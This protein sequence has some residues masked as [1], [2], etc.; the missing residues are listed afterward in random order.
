MQLSG[1][2]LL[3][4]N[5]SVYQDL[6]SPK[7][8][9]AKTS[10][11]F[12]K[13]GPTLLKIDNAYEQYYK[14]GHRLAKESLHRLL[15]D[16]L[17][18]HGGFWDKCKRNVASN[19]L[20][21]FV[22]ELTK[23]N[24]L[25]PLTKEQR[26]KNLIENVEV[27]H[28]RYGILYLL[29]NIEIRADCMPILLEGASAGLAI[30][31][32]S[33]TAN[34]NDV[35]SKPVDNTRAVFSVRGKNFTQADI[36]KR[37]GQIAPHLPKVKGAA[38]GVASAASKIPAA[39]SEIPG[40]LKSAGSY[41]SESL[42]KFEYP[43][44]LA[45]LELSA[46]RIDS[47]FNPITYVAVRS[48]DAANVFVEAAAETFENI[49]KFVGRAIR[50][51]AQ[52]LWKKL[53]PPDADP[54]ASAKNRADYARIVK[55]ATKI[56]LNQVL[57]KSVP[58]I[59]DAIDLGSGLARTVDQAAMRIAS[60][61]DRRHFKLRAGHPEELVNSIHGAMEAGMLKGL[62]STIKGAVGV[63]SQFLFAGVGSVVS[64]L[65]TGI[66][67]L[68]KLVCRV[69]E[70]NR[71]SKFLAEAR[72][73]FILEKSFFNAHEDVERRYLNSNPASM[74]TNADKFNEFFKQ[75][76]KASPILPMIVLNSGICTNMMTMLRIFNDVD[77]QVVGSFDQK[78][79]VVFD[80]GIFRYE[81]FNRRLKIYSAEYLRACGFRFKPAVGG[82]QSV[83]QFLEFALKHG[84]KP[85]IT[86][87]EKAAHVTKQFVMA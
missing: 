22:F 11:F 71:V 51:L 37:S 7:E 38:L 43:A 50:D 85:P 19:G 9:V 55:S 17:I 73:K 47:S 10:L 15:H 6:V 72:E 25:M 4:M 74:V 68:V 87:L 46:G 26:A 1:N 41:V 21:Q 52:V 36:I 82:D 42:E 32:T 80:E 67:W 3:N 62:F 23:S 44:T 59:G 63:T 61:M 70:F 31:S 12:S 84:Q 29:G 20:M 16:Y 2:E 8:W 13:R 54:V 58:F 56:I 83:G 60:Y 49:V 64:A 45:A 5:K 14:T 34:F 57:K 81:Q 40:A 78:M 65:M 28:A 53:N 66:E 75:A 18:E 86:A 48:F 77:Q 24:A 79:R 27:P 30:A 39:L 76:C 69:F 35:K 33:M